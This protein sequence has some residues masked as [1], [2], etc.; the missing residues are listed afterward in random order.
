MGGVRPSPFCKARAPRG[1]ETRVAN[2]PN[3]TA[4]ILTKEKIRRREEGEKLPPVK[5]DDDMAAMA[6]VSGGSK[7]RGPWPRVYRRT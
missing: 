1:R 7:M 3:S 2:M 6:A 4:V 5:G